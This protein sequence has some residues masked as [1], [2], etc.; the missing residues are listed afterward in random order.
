M[1]LITRVVNSAPTD[2]NA[3]GDNNGMTSNNQGATPDA[4]TDDQTQEEPKTVEVGK[5]DVSDAIV[6]GAEDATT[7]N[8]EPTEGE[9][10]P[11]DLPDIND[12]P[13][14]DDDSTDDV[15]STDMNAT[16]DGEDSTN[17]DVDQQLADLNASGSEADALDDSNGNI[18]A[19]EV[20]IDNM[21]IDDLIKSGTERL[22]GMSI[23]QLKEFLEKEGYEL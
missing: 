19:D 8:N 4:N 17:M 14:L 21:S 9:D 3:G 18:S 5:N 6:Q 22:K 15:D 16:A 23:A 7:K 2:N 11:T 10:A 12:V 20:D 13:S 1:A